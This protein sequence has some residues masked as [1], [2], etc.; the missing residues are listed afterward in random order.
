[1]AAL[2]QGW[3]EQ[4]S[5][6]HGGRAYFLHSASGKSTWER[7]QEAVAAF[8][9]F[10][11]PA[12]ATSHQA[13]ELESYQTQTPAQ[14]T[15]TDHADSMFQAVQES[16]I[17]TANSPGATVKNVQQPWSDLP[18]PQGVLPALRTEYMKHDSQSEHDNV[19]DNLGEKAKE[20]YPFGT[21]LHSG[22]IPFLPL[23]NMATLRGYDGMSDNVTVSTRNKD[24]GA[25][26]AD[27]VEK[28]QLHD[29]DID[30]TWFADEWSVP[31]VTSRGP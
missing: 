7:P 12:V 22:P 10:Q 20:K 16:G 14:T 8:T 29:A 6:E 24:P 25:V 15:W 5:V 27:A 19:E 1:M 28:A 17:A 2:P 21:W 13:Y 26:L 9:E 4:I 3:I 11:N 30:A 31:Q 18:P 23:P